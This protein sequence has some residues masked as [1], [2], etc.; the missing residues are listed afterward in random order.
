MRW[1]SRR[2][3]NAFVGCGLV[4]SWLPADHSASAPRRLSCSLLNGKRR[5]CFVGVYRF[6]ERRIPTRRAA[7][8]VH[9]HDMNKPN[10]LNPGASSTAQAVAAADGD[11]VA[12]QPVDAAEQAYE[13]S[14]PG[15]VGNV[16]GA[17]KAIPTARVAQAMMGTSKSDAEQTGEDAGGKST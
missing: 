15:A 11:A 5:G 9:P 16:P 4:L 12:A 2:Q 7:R 3:G 14:P 10:A 8:R 13:N 1:L 17:H 6:T